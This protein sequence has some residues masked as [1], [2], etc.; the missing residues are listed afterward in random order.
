MLGLIGCY[1][2]ILNLRK[3]CRLKV[4][5]LGFLSFKKGYYCY[6]G[7]ALGKNISIE[8]RVKRHKKIAKEKH[9]K[10]RWHIDYLLTYKYTELLGSMF[11]P[12]RSRIECKV[13]KIVESLADKVVQGFGSSDCKLGC[14]G[15]LYYFKH[16]PLRTLTKLLGKHFKLLKV[17]S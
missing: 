5:S 17:K 12:S 7:S 6:I 2:L 8:K 10:L 4:G 1:I 9:G 11:I 15:H 13:S 16:K 14:K 3:N